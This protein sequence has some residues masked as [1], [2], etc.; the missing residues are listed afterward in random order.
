MATWTQEFKHPIDYLL[1]EEGDYLLLEEG[2]TDRLVLEDTGSA[3]S[4]WS[5]QTKN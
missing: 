3:T 4:L 5:T 1:L 2:T